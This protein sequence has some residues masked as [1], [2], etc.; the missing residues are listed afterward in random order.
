MR[1][2]EAI[3][4][5]LGMNKAELAAALGAEVNGVRA[6]MSGRAV[7]RKETVARINAFLASSRHVNSFPVEVSVT[8]ERECHGISR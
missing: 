8:R 5:R 7:G 6:W 2:V 4:L 1:K 3:R